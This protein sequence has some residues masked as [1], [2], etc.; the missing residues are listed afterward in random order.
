MASLTSTHNRYFL[1][2]AIFPNGVALCTAVDTHTSRRS[3]TTDPLVTR[4]WTWEDSRS[5]NP[6]YLRAGGSEHAHRPDS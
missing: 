4:S 3:H 5:G 2:L 1:R 6:R